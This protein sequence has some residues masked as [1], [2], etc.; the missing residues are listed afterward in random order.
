MDLI[1]AIVIAIA[2]SLS[3]DTSD[4]TSTDLSGDSTVTTGETQ[5]MNDG[6]IIDNDIITHQ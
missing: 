6:L 2:G 5:V 4:A 3:T 1:I